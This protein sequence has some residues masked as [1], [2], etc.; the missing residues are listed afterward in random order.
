MS[1]RPSPF[2]SIVVTPSAWSVP[3]RC[4]KKVACGTPYGPLPGVF[5]RSSCAEPLTVNTKSVS[6][7][8]DAEVIVSP[9]VFVFIDVV[10]HANSFPQEYKG[11]AIARSQGAGSKKYRPQMMEISGFRMI[12]K[13][14]EQACRF[15]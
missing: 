3:R 8:A 7:S 2:M 15:G 11:N 13:K 10:T 14:I 5:F 1:G 4:T 6:K 12:L 9:K